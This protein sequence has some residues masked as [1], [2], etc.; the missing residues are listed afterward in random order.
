MTE[1]VLRSSLRTEN[2]NVIGFMSWQN[3]GNEAPF[4]VFGVKCITLWINVYSVT[5]SAF[6][7]YCLGRGIPCSKMFVFLIMCYQY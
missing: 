3:K 5:K 7:L 6:C 2:T 1:A 4:C